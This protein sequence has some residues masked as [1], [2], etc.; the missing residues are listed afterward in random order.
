[1][2]RTCFYQIEGVVKIIPFFLSKKDRFHVD[3]VLQSPT[4]AAELAWD[5]WLQSKVV[6]EGKNSNAEE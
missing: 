2:Y 3:F 6:K 5:S 4:V 1:M